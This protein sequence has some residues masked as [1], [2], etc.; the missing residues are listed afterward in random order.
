MK[1]RNHIYISLV[2]VC[3]A[4]IFEWWIICVIS[5]YYLTIAYIMYDQQKSVKPLQKSMFST[6]ELNKLIG[7]IDNMKGKEFE[8]F[9][10]SL[11]KTKGYGF[12]E[13]TPYD[14]YDTGQTPIYDKIL[15]SCL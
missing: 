10:A 1:A 12:I 5:L 4:Y 14:T 9:I 2:I 8:E 11:F 7:K 6:E 15:H 3:L 13:L